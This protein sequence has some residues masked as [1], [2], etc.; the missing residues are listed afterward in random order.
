MIP[1]GTEHVIVQINLEF[2]QFQEFQME[3]STSGFAIGLDYMPNLFG[4]NIRKFTVDYMHGSTMLTVW[5][6]EMSIIIC[7]VLNFSLVTC[8]FVTYD[9]LS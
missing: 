3:C 9:H 5:I 2:I 8:L 4:K 7:L 6:I 1:L